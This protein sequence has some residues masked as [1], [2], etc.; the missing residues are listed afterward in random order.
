MITPRYDPLAQSFNRGPIWGYRGS[1]FSPKRAAFWLYALLLLVSLGY[2]LLEQ[3]SFLAA[4]PAAW[5]LSVLLMVVVVVPVLILIYRLDQF[6]P[7][8]VSLVVGAFL[9]G[10][11][12]A[13]FFSSATN[14][15]LAAVLENTLSPDVF[16]SWRAAIVAPINEELYKSLGL[17]VLFLI[18]PLE[19]DSLMDGLVYGA[20][21]GLGFQAVEN[22]QYFLQAVDLAGGGDQIGPVIGVFFLRV[23]VGGVYSHV[24]FTSLVGIGFAYV[25][26]RREV[27]RALRAVVFGAL[28][29]AAFLAH[30][31][32]NSPWFESLIQEDNVGTFVAYAFVKGIPFLAFLLVLVFMA[33]RREANAFSRLVAAEVGTD[34]IG[35]GELAIL[36]SAR[37]RRRARRAVT[38]ARG[39]AAGRVLAAL[40]KEQLRLAL[41]VSK[42]VDP[43]DPRVE[44]Q[45]N[46][47]RALRAQLAQVSAWGR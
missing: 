10:A 2:T 25:V 6:E 13:V 16:V 8:P 24:L 17:V 46:R 9:W 42:A 32:W 1:L 40:Q 18:A 41:V 44:Y 4:Y 26:T 23:V 34:V 5:A 45:R 36:R 35:E 31:V 14:S 39:S 22:V 38:A 28:Y 27:S 11:V 19:F 29:A 33:R 30:F 43:A 15:L 7:E 21:I 37:R 12:V 3:G 47:I 20:F